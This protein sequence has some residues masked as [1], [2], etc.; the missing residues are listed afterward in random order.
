MKLHAAAVK[1]HFDVKTHNP[2]HHGKDHSYDNSTIKYPEEFPCRLC[3]RYVLKLRIYFFGIRL[4]QGQKTRAFVI[5]K[6]KHC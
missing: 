5:H 6:N 4:P 2:A 1:G 3:G